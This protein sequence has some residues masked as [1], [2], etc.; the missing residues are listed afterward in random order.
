MHVTGQIAASGTFRA[1]VTRAEVTRARGPR[2]GRQS[3]GWWK[4]KQFWRYTWREL[5]LWAAVALLPLLRRLVPGL[6]VAHSR[7]YAKVVHADGSVTDFGLVGK[8]LVVTAGKNYV[9]A[10][11]DNTN[12]PENLKFH[13]YGTGTTAAASGDTALQTELTTQYATDNAR[14]TGTQAHSTNTYTTVG[15]LSPDATV[16]ITEWGLLSQASNAGGTLFDHQ[17]FSAINL[18]SGDSLATTYVLTQS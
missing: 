17:V 7:L 13:G 3:V 1:K 11:F 9:A 6:N 5:P 14:P 2:P 12:E 15:T 8:H 16:A 18:V 10:C 4:V